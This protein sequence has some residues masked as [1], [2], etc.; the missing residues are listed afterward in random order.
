NTRLRHH[1]A[2]AH[3]GCGSMTVQTASLVLW[4]AGAADANGQGRTEARRRSQCGAEAAQFN[5]A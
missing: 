1:L 5:G 2:N 3:P 4:S